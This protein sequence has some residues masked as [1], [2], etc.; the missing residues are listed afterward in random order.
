MSSLTGGLKFS[1]LDLFSAYQQLP[2]DVEL[3]EYVTV[4]T[5]HGLH[6][7]PC[8]PFGIA[9]AWPFFKGNG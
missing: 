7:C 9:S 8:L 6:Y 3:R 4:N 2:L 1:K 5:H